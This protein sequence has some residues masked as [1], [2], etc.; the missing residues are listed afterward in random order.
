M[1]FTDKIF[2][3]A[4]KSTNALLEHPISNVTKTNYDYPLTFD[5]VL[6][7]LKS[8][9]YKYVYLWEFDIETVIWLFEKD[10]LENTFVRHAAKELRKIFNKERKF[11]AVYSYFIWLRYFDYFRNK[12]KEIVYRTTDPKR[13]SLNEINSYKNVEHEAQILIIGLE[14]LETDEEKNGLLKLL[15]DPKNQQSLSKDAFETA[16]TYIRTCLSKKGLIID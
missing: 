11:L 15:E 14:A 2:Q 16:K 8:H 7:K 6:Q 9:S 12:L 3:E 1:L 13:N 5:I 10:H 4:I